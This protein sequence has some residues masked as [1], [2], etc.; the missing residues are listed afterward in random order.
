MVQQDR[1]G[2][3]GE[4]R[5]MLFFSETVPTDQPGLSMRF[6]LGMPIYAQLGEAN[7]AHVVHDVAFR[8]DPEIAQ[9]EFDIAATGNAHV[10]TQGYYLWWPANDFPGDK[11]AL[12][13]TRRMAKGIQS[14]SPEGTTGGSLHPEPVLPGT[15]RQVASPVALPDYKGQYYLSLHLAGT[16][17]SFERVLRLDL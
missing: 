17:S 11:K 8:Q 14:T 1:L 16:S 6:R 12:K 10:R 2:A 9:I 7:P 4:H 15:R 3:N 5:A 13:R